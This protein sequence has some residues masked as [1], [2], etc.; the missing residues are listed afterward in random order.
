MAK[1]RT[2]GCFKFLIFLLLAIPASLAIS[3]YVNGENPIDFIKETLG[4][5]SSSDSEKTA[6]IDRGSTTSSNSTKEISDLNSEINELRNEIR[7]L[8]SENQNLRNVIKEKDKEIKSLS[9]GY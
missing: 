9:E 8:E 2:T 4:Q 5:T 6:T 3:S 1:Y 7:T